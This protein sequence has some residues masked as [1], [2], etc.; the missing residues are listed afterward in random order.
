MK[1][2]NKRP[3]LNRKNNIVAATNVFQKAA[4]EAHSSMDRG[5]VGMLNKFLAARYDPSS[6]ML[7]LE[8]RFDHISIRQ[9]PQALHLCI[10]V[11]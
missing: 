5:A 3:G 4:R 7:N 8:V 9:N 1:A 2:A 6:R 11:K 10:S